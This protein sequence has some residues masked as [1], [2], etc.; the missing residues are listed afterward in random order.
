[1]AGFLS[2]LRRDCIPNLRML[3]VGFT[4]IFQ[5]YVSNPAIKV[6]RPD[7]LRGCQGRICYEKKDMGREENLTL[8]KPG[9]VCLDYVGVEGHVA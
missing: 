4:S 3:T 5:G 8:G 2:L 1:M 7:Q 6:Y 9:M